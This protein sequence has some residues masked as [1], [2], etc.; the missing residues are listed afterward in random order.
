[1]FNREFRRRGQNVFSPLMG[2]LI[3]GADKFSVLH[4]KNA[5]VAL[6]VADACGLRIKNLKRSLGGFL[7][8]TGRFTVI[9]NKKQILID[10]SY[11]ANPASFENALAM[12]SQFQTKGR[13]V[14][15]CGDML[16][17]G[18]ASEE[19]HRQVGFKAADLA[20]DYVIS[21]GDQAQLIAEG[22]RE[23][24]KEKQAAVCVK[25]REEALDLLRKELREDD[26][27]LFK[28]SRGMRF[29]QL[30]NNLKKDSLIPR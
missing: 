7:L 14:L 25:N 12:F 19:L 9:P 1:L 15:V 16:E 29:D 8:P 23:R 17:L 27:I 10:D 26:I 11:N 18:E 24:K 5:L 3:F 20:T 21:V 2:I 28:A 13:R 22:F 30:V 4:I 6:V